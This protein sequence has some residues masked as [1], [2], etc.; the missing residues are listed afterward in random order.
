[1]IKITV[2]MSPS[3]LADF[4]YD[5]QN[6]ELKARMFDLEDS[7]T[8]IDTEHK[9]EHVVFAIVS[10]MQIV[11]I[12]DLYTEAGIPFTVQDV[13]IDA[14]FSF[15]DTQDE[16]VKTTFGN[17]WRANEFVQKYVRTYAE[18]N[19]VLDKINKYGK[20]SLTEADH[21]VLESL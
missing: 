16:A 7:V 9:G 5:M 17:N 3:D 15:H 19:D 14:I 1:M 8:M 6:E 18:V 4:M 13:T 20:D 10:E 12:K 2:H 21:F 11:Q